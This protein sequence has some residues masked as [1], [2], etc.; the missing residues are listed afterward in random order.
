M[1]FAGWNRAY[2]QF[3]ANTNL[4]T[5]A[6]LEV[7]LGSA[8]T[9]PMVVNAARPSRFAL[10]IENLP[11]DGWLVGTGAALGAPAGAFASPTPHWRATTVPITRAT[12]MAATIRF[13]GRGRRGA[14]IDTALF[15]SA[16][17][18]GASWATTRGGGTRS[19]ALKTAS[20]STCD[21]C[22]T[23]TFSAS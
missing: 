14:S 21:S 2:R 18:R 10:E 6:T 15:V 11:V 5:G 3:F 23:S 4:A 22:R 7:Q 17:G 20:C 1:D 8:R 12:A 19:G 16:W 13:V 9:A